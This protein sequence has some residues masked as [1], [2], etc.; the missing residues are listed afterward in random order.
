[1]NIIYIVGRYITLLKREVW[2]DYAKSL[3]RIEI[4][5]FPSKIDNNDTLINKS[6]YYIPIIKVFFLMRFIGGEPITCD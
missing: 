3:R 5:D 4:R 6:Y 2:H 1:M